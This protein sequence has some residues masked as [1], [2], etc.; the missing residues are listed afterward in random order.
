MICVLD[1]HLA[2]PEAF[3]QTFPSRGV[4]SGKLF[5]AIIR[6]NWLLKGVW[7]CVR[8][9]AALLRPGGTEPDLRNASINRNN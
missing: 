3:P 4:V 9:N 1:V 5:F 7:T 8:S 2:L 6:T